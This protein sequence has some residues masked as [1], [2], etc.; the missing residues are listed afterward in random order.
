M[1]IVVLEQEHDAYVSDKVYIKF[2]FVNRI[3][4]YVIFSNRRNVKYCVLYMKEMNGLRK[5][6]QSHFSIG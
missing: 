3:N 5:Y 1:H 2:L 4:V 6:L